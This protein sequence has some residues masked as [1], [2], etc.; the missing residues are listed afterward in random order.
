VCP[1][2][3]GGRRLLV[4]GLHTPS[5]GLA[6]RQQS[7]QAFPSPTRKSPPL[8]RTQGE[9]SLLFPKHPASAANASG[10]VQTDLSEVPPR[11]HSSRQFR[12]AALPISPSV[13]RPLSHRHT[14][15]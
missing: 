4:S 1:H 9:T 15:H 3:S 11:I 2:T 13:S 6:V 7:P 10:S 8:S 14:R 5:I 12:A